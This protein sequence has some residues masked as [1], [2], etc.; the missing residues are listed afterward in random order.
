VLDLGK[1]LFDRVQVGAVG[2]QEEQVC[3]LGAND[4]ASR[5]AFV[6]REIV[7][8]DDVSFGQGRSQLLFDIER[9]YLAVDGTVDDP[10]SRDAIAAKRRDECQRLPVAEGSGRRQPLPVRPPAAQRSHVGLDPGL[11]DENEAGNID[12]ALM[13]LPACP[14]TGDVGAVLL[15]RPHRF[16]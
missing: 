13:N 14:L 5:L 16:F 2:R 3:S 7:E 8:D 15:G 1:D 10:G 6:A 12:L 4:V 9:E 11:V